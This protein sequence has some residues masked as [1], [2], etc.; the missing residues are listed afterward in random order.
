MRGPLHATNLPH[1]PLTPVVYP[2]AVSSSHA[3]NVHVG[4]VRIKSCTGEKGNAGEILHSFSAPEGGGNP[5]HV[6]L[7]HAAEERTV[8]EYVVS[9]HYSDMQ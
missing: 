7:M 1:L 5:A 9:N 4:L 3:R 6:V 2:D 8:L